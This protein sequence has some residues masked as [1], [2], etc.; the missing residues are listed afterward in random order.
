MTTRTPD[1][2]KD[3]PGGGKGVAITREATEVRK[4]ILLSLNI[5]SG[6]HCC[7]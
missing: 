1:D 4:V 5:Y 7:I 3:R 2:S 6:S